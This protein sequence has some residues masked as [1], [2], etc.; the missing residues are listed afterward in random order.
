MSL[1]ALAIGVL[2]LAQVALGGLF[3]FRV[4]TTLALQE[5]AA[6]ALSSHPP[7]ENPDYYEDTA[8]YRRRVFQLGGAMLLLL[9]VGLVGVAGY[10]LLFVPEFPG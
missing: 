10:A 5:R 8:A 4:E 7:S 2:G 3:V 9:G 6:E 1:E